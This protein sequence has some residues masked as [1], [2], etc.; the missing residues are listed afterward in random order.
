MI[1]VVVGMLDELPPEVNAF[2]GMSSNV[3]GMHS[4][5]FQMSMA[6]PKYW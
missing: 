1:V 6:H 2:G 5:I 4:Q 3:C